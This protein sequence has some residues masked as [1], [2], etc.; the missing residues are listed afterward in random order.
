DDA[1]SGR[2]GE[3]QARH[4]IGRGSSASGRMSSSY[5]DAP[6][7]PAVPVES[8]GNGLQR[9]ATR[10]AEA[11]TLIPDLL[12]IVLER[13]AS[14]LH[15]TAGSPPV[16]RQLGDLVRLDEYPTLTPQSLRTMIYAII[17]QRQRERLEQDL[18]LDMSYSVVGKARF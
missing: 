5:G 2:T 4:D 1:A 11:E 15:L 8:T 13:G 17:S 14:D 7:P 12:D 18:E 9:I 3:G 16:L 10:P 6:R